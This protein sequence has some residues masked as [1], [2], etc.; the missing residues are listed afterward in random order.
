M[1]VL[2]KALCAMVLV[3]ASAVVW[4][5]DLFHLVN[6]ES[7]K[8]GLDPA[9][10]SPKARVAWGWVEHNITASPQDGLRAEAVTT[11]EDSGKIGLAH[12]QVQGKHTA[13]FGA[14]STPQHN[15]TGKAGL[16]FFG[17]KSA[18]QFHY[19]FRKKFERKTSWSV[20]RSEL[21]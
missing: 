10:L 15:I 14:N 5:D 13:Y 18:H 2:Y 11:F 8:L 16:S 21:R 12:L 1:H 17:G 19:I 6:E 4:S 20:S 7:F 3:C 9:K